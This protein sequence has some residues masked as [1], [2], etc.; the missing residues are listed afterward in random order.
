VSDDEPKPETPMQ[1]ALR[2]KQ[3]AQKARVKPPRG[4]RGDAPDNPGARNKPW[5]KR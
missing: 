5:M 3:A 4:K 1:K 2:L